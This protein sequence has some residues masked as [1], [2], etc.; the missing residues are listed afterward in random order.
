MTQ[1]K[2]KK[3]K[4]RKERKEYKVENEVR[5]NNSRPTPGP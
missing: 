5:E 1:A 4:N 2:R 3:R